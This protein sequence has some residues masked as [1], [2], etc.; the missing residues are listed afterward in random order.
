M[1]ILLLLALAQE[2]PDP[3]RIAEAVAKGV[4]LLTPAAAA[5]QQELELILL[6]L[7]HGGV[8][9]ADP[10]FAAPLERACG[11]ELKMTYRAALLA[12]TL[13][14]VD[15]LRH[16]PRI[17]RCAQFLL[18][19]QGETGQ[20]SYGR[21]TSYPAPDEIPEPGDLVIFEE[22]RA[23]AAPKRRIRVRQQRLLEGVGDNSNT[24]YA[25]LG[26]RACHDAGISLPVEAIERALAW[27]KKSQDD[28]GG[29]GYGG[30]GSPTGPM[31]AGAMG[32]RGIL[33]H[34]LG[35]D[36]RQDVALKQGAAWLGAHLKVSTGR[37]FS[38][39]G[40]YLYGVE[41]AGILC[42][43]ERFG[44]HD[45]YAWGSAQLLAAQKPNGGWGST[46]DTAFAVLFLRRATRSMVESGR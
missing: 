23:K 37:I 32:S 36:W 44:P 41:R 29:W 24:A 42:A 14:E 7:A 8:A 35:R 28:A 38:V 43:L 45:W 17:A 1:S 16:Q 31:T 19:S 40:Y 27:W 3:A 18:D 2:N 25:A 21:P 4:R 26:L 46:A 13:Q 15:P 22:P 5:A 39:N 10:A 6:A 9:S 33:L 12:M 11:L 30:K 20:W 34:L